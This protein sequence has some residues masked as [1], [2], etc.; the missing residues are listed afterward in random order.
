MFAYRLEC[1]CFLYILHAKKKIGIQNLIEFD[2][3]KKKILIETAPRLKV[4][5]ETLSTLRRHEIYRFGAFLF[6][7]SQ[8]LR[9][10]WL[11]VCSS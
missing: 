10:E 1:N 8:A 11:Y 9:T 3:L 2:Y 4:T 6:A 7:P 5:L